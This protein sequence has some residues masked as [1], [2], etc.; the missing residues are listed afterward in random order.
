MQMRVSV[1]PSPPLIDEK[2]YIIN[3]Q[4]PSAIQI[5][6]TGRQV[7]R[8]FCDVPC[9]A[10]LHAFG[11]IKENQNLLKRPPEIPVI[12]L[13]TGSIDRFSVLRK[14]T[15]LNFCETG[16]LRKG[17]RQE[18]AF[19]TFTPR[20]DDRLDISLLLPRMLRN[21]PDRDLE[22][23]PTTQLIAVAPFAGSEAEAEGWGEEGR[24]MVVKAVK[25]S[26]VHHPEK[27]REY[28]VNYLAFHYQ[29]HGHD[30]VAS[31]TSATP[32]DSHTRYM[33]SSCY[34]FRKYGSLS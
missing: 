24:D 25:S 12:S 3:E 6:S 13:L 32:H 4:C 28:A 1:L 21:F 20:E 15:F 23:R 33:C 19:R 16:R 5:R 14:R 34:F 29:R 30:L 22:K 18:K 8:N 7:W 17:L 2:S 27:Q 9:E 10:F 31:N 11:A 26:D